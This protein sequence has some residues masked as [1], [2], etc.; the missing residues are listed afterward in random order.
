MEENYYYNKQTF[1][2]EEESGFDIKEWISLFL[3][4]WYLFIIFGLLALGL[5]YK[6]GNTFS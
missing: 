1:N 6:R 2:D 3:H 5:A 4:F